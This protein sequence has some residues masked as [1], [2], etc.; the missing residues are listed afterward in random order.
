MVERDLGKIEA[1]GSIPIGSSS[2]C[3]SSSVGRASPCQGERREFES[4]LP[5]HFRASGEMAYTMVLEA[6]ALRRT[7]SSPV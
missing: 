7:G 5:L 6:I 2:L 3:G 1:I 4:L